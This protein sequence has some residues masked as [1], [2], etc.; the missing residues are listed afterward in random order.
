MTFWTSCRQ[1]REQGGKQFFSSNSLVEAWGSPRRET[2][3]SGGGTGN[4]AA[5]TV[6]KRGGI[7]RRG[8]AAIVWIWTARDVKEATQA[9]TRPLGC[10]IPSNGTPGGPKER[11][12]DEEGNPETANS[13]RIETLN[14]RM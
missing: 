4:K 13:I 6:K 1:K 9:T 14:T 10:R 8:A 7:Q 12:K 5:G 11:G 2:T 3:S